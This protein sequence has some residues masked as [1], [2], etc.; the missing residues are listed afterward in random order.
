MLVVAMLSQVT[1]VTAQMNL[2]I[3]GGVNMSNF[4]G[5]EIDDKNV[6]I[7]FHIG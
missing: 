7:G 6:K 2:G 1:A 3:K 4:Y 5:D